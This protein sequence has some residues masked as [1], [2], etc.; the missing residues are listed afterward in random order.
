MVLLVFSTIG[1]GTAYASESVTVYVR[2]EGQSQTIWR[3]T[4]SLSGS[5]TIDGHEVSANSPL[6]A[7]HAAS[8]AGGFSYTVTWAGW[9]VFV[10]SIAGEAYPMGSPTGWI[11]MVNFEIVW[12]SADSGPPLVEGDEV[13]WYP[14]DFSETPLK[15]S[16]DKTSV[17]AGEAFKVTVTTTEQNP[18]V[19]V[20]VYA[21]SDYTTGADGK[22]TITIS[23][24]GSYHV[25]AEDDGYIRSDKVLVR[26]G[27]GGGGYSERQ[28]QAVEDVEALL[29]MPLSVIAGEEAAVAGEEYDYNGDG[30]VDVADAFDQFVDVGVIGEPGYSFEP[31]IADSFLAS[32]QAQYGE[33]L[34]KFPSVE[35]RVWLLYM[36]GYQP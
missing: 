25:Y 26:V 18:A 5:F 14:G 16:V 1:A 30:M 21:D 3:G 2:I 19:G 13:L 10:D 17:K 7:L 31:Q 9:G 4:V 8:L 6:G 29:D 33:N 24:S 35:G 23:S 20:T 11:Y 36:L 27:G 15:I 12:A 34:E 28:L 32:L 22:A